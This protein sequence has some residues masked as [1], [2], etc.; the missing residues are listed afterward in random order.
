MKIRNN[1]PL[2][3]ICWLNHAQGGMIGKY[4]EPESREELEKLCRSLYKQRK[5]FDLIGHTS[6]IYFLPSYSCDIMVSTRKVKNIYLNEDSIVAD[7]GVSVAR[8]AIE[9]VKT[10]IEGFEGLIDLPGTVGAAVYGNASC[11]GCSINQMLISLE[12]LRPDGSVV[13]LKT[14]DLYLTKRSSA[15][16]RGELGGVILSATLRKKQGNPVLLQQLAVKNHKKRLETQPGP[17]DNLGSIYYN[18]EGWSMFSILPRGIVAIYGILLKIAGLCKDNIKEKKKRALLVV[19][20]GK[21][22]IPYFYGWNRYIWSDEQSHKLFWKYHRLHQLMF[23]NS[24]F[25]IEIK[26]DNLK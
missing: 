17:K 23:K 7:C 8:L 20:G 25:E 16:K 18:S 2:Y 26:G 9:M 1:I 14:D 10:G 6:N 5:M 4:Y 12:M 22:V 21:R 24:T 3:S 15:L 19:L 11:Y 13:T